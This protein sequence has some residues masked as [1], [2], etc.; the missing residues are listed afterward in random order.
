MKR[1]QSSRQAGKLF[2]GRVE[3]RGCT[4]NLTT[5]FVVSSLEGSVSDNSL[6]RDL[7]YNKAYSL[8]FG[9]VPWIFSKAILLITHNLENFLK[10]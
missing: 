7:R 10:W 1:P 5:N 8:D 3:S 9:F 6:I 4:E 2:A